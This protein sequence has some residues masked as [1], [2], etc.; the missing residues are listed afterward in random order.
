MKE[1]V[2]RVWAE[3]RSRQRCSGT[4]DNRDYGPAHNGRSRVKNDLDGGRRPV[5]GGAWEEGEAEVK[6]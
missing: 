1:L 5:R 2:R 3:L 4:G 6:E